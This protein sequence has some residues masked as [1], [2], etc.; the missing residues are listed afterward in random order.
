MNAFGY[1]RGGRPVVPTFEPN[2][3]ISL[4]A[5]EKQIREKLDSM[6]QLP[7]MP[8]K[9][10]RSSLVMDMDPTL[11]KLS[12]DVRDLMIAWQ[13]DSSRK[14]DFEA[15]WKL[16]EARFNA[17]KSDPEFGEKLTEALGTARVSNQKD[18]LP[19]QI[20]TLQEKLTR[21]GLMA[22]AGIT[23]IEFDP[24][25]PKGFTEA[26]AAHFADHAPQKTETE[27][28]TGVGHTLAK[29]AHK[30]PSFGK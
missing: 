11:R 22:E 9:S 26:L 23:H 15:A 2:H 10:V 7:A 5:M 16:A 1:N 13:T 30:L 3:G 20:L 28:Q 14:A 6:T 24:D 8:D 27:Y 21:I 4:A 17:L 25:D 18:S 19:M 12:E 29:L